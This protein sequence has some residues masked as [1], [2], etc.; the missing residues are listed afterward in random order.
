MPAYE[1]IVQGALAAALQEFNCHSVSEYKRKVPSVTKDDK[2]VDEVCDQLAVAFG[3]EILNT[4]PGY[5][6]TEINAN[7][8][9]DTK[10]SIEK[11]KKI[12]GMYEK[13]GVDAKKRVLIKLGSTWESIQACKELQGQGIQCNMT[14]LFS[15]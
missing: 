13:K 11:A 6:S 8:S 7:L 1:K 14:L 15:F 2:L 10:A 5:V 4:V 12:M 9:F 3:V